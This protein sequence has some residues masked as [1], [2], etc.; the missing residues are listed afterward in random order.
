M[1]DVIFVC[2]LRELFVLKSSFHFMILLF[3]LSCISYRAKFLLQGRPGVCS[4]IVG[5]GQKVR[6]TSLICWVFFFS[7]GND[8]A[9]HFFF[10]ETQEEIIKEVF[11]EQCEKLAFYFRKLIL[12][13]ISQVK[14]MYY[15]W[16]YIHM[17]HWF[18]F[19][20]YF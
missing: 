15:W 14:P 2:F 4:W 11:I 6:S 1:L 7:L 20:F 12:W 9:S 18:F 19:M 16:N 13:S 8:Q 17:R 5:G 3:E 10:C